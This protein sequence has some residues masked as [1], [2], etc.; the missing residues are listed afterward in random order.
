M[1]SY[2][3]MDQIMNKQAINFIS[4]L[5]F[6]THNKGCNRSQEDTKHCSKELCRSQTSTDE[7]IPV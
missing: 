2:K 6:L 3:F 4:N 5:A 1:E 7:D